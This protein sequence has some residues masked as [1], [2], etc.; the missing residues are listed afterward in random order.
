MMSPYPNVLLQVTGVGRVTF[1]Y[2]SAVTLIKISPRVVLVRLPN[3]DHFDVSRMSVSLACGSH[4]FEF[5][6]DRLQCDLM[7][8]SDR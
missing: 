2:R 3:Q 7:F 6:F 4:V 1:G 5:P 8:Q